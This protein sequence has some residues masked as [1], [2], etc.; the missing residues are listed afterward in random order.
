[1]IM[2][3]IIEDL[4]HLDTH[5]PPVGQP[6]GDLL[7]DTV[8]VRPDNLDFPTGIPNMLG[9]PPVLH[10]S[11]NDSMGGRVDIIHTKGCVTNAS[12]TVSSWFF[13]GTCLI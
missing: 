9:S 4:I 11:S 5:L 10:R 3:I 12:L 1:M 2:M 7:E 13:E 8:E 6:S